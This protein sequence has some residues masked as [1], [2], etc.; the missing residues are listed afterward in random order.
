MKRM[1]NTL[2]VTTQGSYLVRDNECVVVRVQKEN[3]LRVPLHGLDGIV[4]F[5]RVA[6][7]PPLMGLCAE[8]GISISFLNERGRFWGRVH[9]PVSGNVHLRMEQYRRSTDEDA[10]S[11][12]ARAML[13]G[14]I[15]GSRCVLLRAMRDHVANDATDQISSAAGRLRDIARHLTRPL[16]LDVARGYEGEAGKLYFGVFNHLIV[17]QKDAF[18][19]ER[20]TRRPPTDRVNAMLSFI[21][22]ILAHDTMSALEGVGLD[23]AVGFLH[24]LRP[25][26]PGLALDVMEEFRPFLADRLIL[27]LINRQQVKAQ[28]F[29]QTVTDAVNMDDDTRKLLIRAYQ[30]RKQEEILHPFLNEKIQIGL[31]P[32]VQ[33]MLLARHLRGDLDAYPPFVWR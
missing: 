27:S 25:G 29:A 31:L 1:L 13:I 19:F 17:A 10:T 6:C 5:G 15:A 14:K 3:R 20:R 18:S 26:R 21:Y 16:T 12:I 24:R 22:A 23:P 30:E 9:G 32:H 4:C 2:Y 8:R 7:S 33:A 28:G 11:A